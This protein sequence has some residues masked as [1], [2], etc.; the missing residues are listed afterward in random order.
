MRAFVLRVPAAIET[1]PLAQEE[2]PT[3]EPGPR[4]LRIRVHAC[5]ACRTDLHV[6]E[7]E[8]AQ[9][10]A[11]VTPG[12]QVVGTVDAIGA[13]VDPAWLGARAGV[14]W[15]HA[16]CGVC[17]FCRRGAE[18]LCERATFTGYTEQGGYAEHV[19]AQADF[20]YPLPQRLSDEQVAPLLCAG[21]IGY[22]ALR[23]TEL[24]SWAGARL[25]IYGFGA[26]GHIAIQLARAR[27]AEVYVATREAVHRELAR[28]LGATWVGGTVER[29]PVPLDA[30]VVFAPAGEIV[31]AA[32]S[33]LDRGGTL[34]L[35]GIHMSD[36]PAMPYAL[37]YGERT[38]RSVANNTREDGRA[39]LEEAAQAG[40][41]TH[42]TVY[43]FD[44][45]NEALQALKRGV[46]GAAV[47]RIQPAS[48]F[49]L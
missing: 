36:I 26:A 6:I 4:Q 42:V 35:G 16:T 39:F 7:G 8:L 3:P 40:V 41:T 10:L 20:V 44:Q 22:R 21:I 31:P 14:A 12:H 18:N 15:L 43:P 49:S 23:R 48:G 17:R 33:H 5:A 28:E 38:L 46:P 11:P 1:S 25:G 19:L 24:A 27:G 9:Q 30:A 34:V 45:V 47:V 37:L 2:L 32:L 29:P 13:E